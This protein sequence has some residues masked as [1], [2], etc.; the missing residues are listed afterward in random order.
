MSRPS[1]YSVSVHEVAVPMSDGVVLSGRV[2]LPEGAGPVPAVL[3]YLPYRKSDSTAI[4]DSVRHP[5]FAERGYA[6]VRVDIR[7]SGDSEGLLADEYQPQEQEDAL[8]LLSWI[9]AQ[10]WCDGSIG[11]M[12][13]SWGGFNSLQMAARR[14]PQLKA[15][16]TACSTDDR[17]ADDVHYMGG[18]VLGYYM[19]P[20]ASVMLA[21]N[22]R[23]PD[24]TVVGDRWREM[25]LERLE[26]NEFL[27]EKWLSHQRRDAYWKQGSVCE[28]YAAIEC[29]VYLVG[30]WSDGYTNAIFR[31][32]EGLSCPRR[33][34]IGPWE[35]VWPEQGVPGP[36]IGFLQEEIRWWDHWLKGIDTG[37]MDEPLVRA[38][39]QDSEPPRTA[40]DT[41]Q[42]HWVA[43]A[44]W[45]T[46]NVRQETL[47]V[48]EGG[49]AGEALP[50]MPIPPSQL[51][52]RSPQTVGVDAG[53]WLPYANPADLPGDQR[54]DNARSL[55]VT[56]APLT[57]PLELLGQPRA[58]LTLSSDQ[59]QGVVAVRLCDVRPD[60]SV[61]LISRAILN[62]T[63]AHSHEHPTPLTPGA[64][65][66]YDIPL[67]A[68]A[69]TVPAG[70]R[71]ELAV[72]TSY[73]PW[74]WPTPVPTTITLH[75]GAGSRL[76]LPVRT[77]QPGDTDL[78]PFGEPETAP[79]LANEILRERRPH[80]TISRDVASGVVE[81]RMR[82]S[83]WGARRL[84]DGLEYWDDDPC[85]FTI[86]DDDP[87]SATAECA[88]TLEIRRGEWR[89]RIE[90]TANMTS[91][92]T[93]FELSATLKVYEGDDMV[94]SKDY[95]ARVPRD[96][97][98]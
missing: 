3:E 91:T 95:D 23:P 62:L 98:S 55:R 42:G 6:G 37:I 79:P 20:W 50:S 16:I 54:Q 66:T 17:Y 93:E 36:A 56:G 33:A 94:F 74:I 51:V 83:L 60:G 7:G 27:A 88:R 24:P 67:K 4:D 78:S 71:L 80:V 9:A 89:T 25:W 46:P 18:S 49:L 1:Q 82:R 10:T 41:R 64:A 84:P 61:A 57:E 15:I 73:W 32:L 19:L 47:Y 29:P 30:G 59:T 81:Y 38:Y 13:I 2:W 85:V 68:I 35:H 77:P 34:V 63:H 90:M 5:Y 97:A 52:H 58:T 72:S 22:A 21:Y 65:V 8:E 87:L 96:D 92:S 48:T 75:T 28:D 70:H 86:R 12:G 44:D 53:S 26:A 76:T 40:Y 31:M 69:Y 11:M 14:P 43:E 39:M 45:P